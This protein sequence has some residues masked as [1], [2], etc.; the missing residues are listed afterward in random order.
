[1]SVAYS[2]KN[3]KYPAERLKVLLLY[4]ALDD[5]F[6]DCKHFG[7]NCDEKEEMIH[8]LKG[9]FCDNQADVSVKGFNFAGLKRNV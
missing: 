4:N 6:S 9:S 3:L 8:F 2:S 1:M 7:V 5:L